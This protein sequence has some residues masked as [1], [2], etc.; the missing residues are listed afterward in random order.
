MIYNGHVK[1][2]EELENILQESLP[3]KAQVHFAYV[4]RNAKGPDENDYVLLAYWSLGKRFYGV[5]GGRV[6]FKGEAYPWN[7]TFVAFDPKSPDK[8]KHL[9][10]EL[11]RMQRVTAM[12]GKAGSSIESAL[13][14]MV[15]I[16]SAWLDGHD[17]NPEVD[18]AGIIGA[19]PEMPADGFGAPSH[20]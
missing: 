18:Y 1:N 14:R 2:R 19:L 16:E 11:V 5:A 13:A 20:N 7:L 12:S 3:K 17:T 8:R 15:E 10:T 6:I 4:F 9:K